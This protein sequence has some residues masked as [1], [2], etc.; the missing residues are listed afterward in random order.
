M[1]WYTQGKDPARKDCVLVKCKEDARTLFF[2][3]RQVR[4]SVA[5]GQDML[6][7]QEH[8]HE[9]LMVWSL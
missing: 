6:H 9:L 3:A 2:D 5:L 8:A 7:R 1:A 4:A